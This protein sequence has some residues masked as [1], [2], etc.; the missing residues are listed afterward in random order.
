MAK[1]WE[2]NKKMK[3]LEVVGAIFCCNKKVLAMQRGEGKYSYSSF[4][5]EFPGGKIEAG[6]SKTEALKRELRE[7]MNVEVAISESQYFTTVNYIYSDFSITMDTYL[8]PVGTFPFS[9]VVHVGHQWV[10]IERIRDLDWL[11]ADF[12]II[13]LL[14]ERGII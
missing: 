4:K 5:Y 13:E 14:I 10:D 11:G 1:R 9:E 2:G 8:I 6:E 7:E 12:P 3:H